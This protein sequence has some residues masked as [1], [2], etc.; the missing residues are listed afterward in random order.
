MSTLFVTL[1]F[2]SPFLVPA[3]TQVDDRNPLFQTVSERAYVDPGYQ[4][5]VVHGRQ[6][7]RAGER[8]RTRR[9]TEWR[10]RYAA[11]QFGS[12]RGAAI[13]ELRRSL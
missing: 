3:S 8:R 6:A 4:C 11:W 1:P 9:C 7:S 10:P 5:F 13:G 2:I 12:L